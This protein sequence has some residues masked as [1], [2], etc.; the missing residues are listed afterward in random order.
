MVITAVGLVIFGQNWSFLVM[1]VAWV[2]LFGIIIVIKQGGLPWLVKS[3]NPI[4]GFGSSDFNL[5]EPSLAWN[6][7]KL[8]DILWTKANSVAHFIKQRHQ[9]CHRFVTCCHQNFMVFEFLTSTYLSIYCLYRNA[10]I[11]FQND[12]QFWTNQKALFWK[13]P[14]VP[15]GG[16]S[17]KTSPTQ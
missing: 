16:R 2:V 1:K 15:Y 17:E 6:T 4:G 7:W 14:W 9:Y 8:F 12:A 13:P 5:L 10:F 11:G 3:S